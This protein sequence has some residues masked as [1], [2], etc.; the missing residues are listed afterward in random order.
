MKTFHSIVTKKRYGCA[1]LSN[2]M[3]HHNWLFIK[4]S[5]EKIFANLI[6]SRA[7]TCPTANCSKFPTRSSCWC[8]TPAWSPATSPTTSSTRSPPSSPSSGHFSRVRIAFHT[9]RKRESGISDFQSQ[10][11]GWLGFYHSQ[12]SLLKLDQ[13]GWDQD[14]H[15]QVSNGLFTGSWFSK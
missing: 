8:R 4:F 5:S 7:Q 6:S 10:A 3:F 1:T 9:S 12:L 15:S 13:R 2:R 11:V 14:F